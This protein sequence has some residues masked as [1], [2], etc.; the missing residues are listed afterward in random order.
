MINPTPAAGAKDRTPPA[1]LCTTK[2]WKDG[3]CKRHHPETIEKKIKSDELW[4]KNKEQRFLENKKLISEKREH[5]RNRELLDLGDLTEQKCVMFLLDIGYT[6]A[7][8]E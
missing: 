6:L 7:K 5:D 8:S 4:E 3:Y 1:R 2:V